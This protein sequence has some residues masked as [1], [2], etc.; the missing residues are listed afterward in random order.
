MLYSKYYLNIGRAT[1]LKNR[2]ERL[3][4]R[5]FEILP[6]F[7]IWTTLILMVFLSWRKPYWAAVFIII[8]CSYWILRTTHFTVHLVAAYRKMKQ[9][10]LINW[11]EKLDNL[12]K[13]S[14]GVKVKS[15]KEIYHLVILPMYKE[16]EEVIRGTMEALINSDYPKDKI[17]VV[18]AV[19]ERAG[20]SAKETANRME[21]EYGERFFRFLVT[22]HPANISGEIIGKGSNETWAG[23]EAKNKIIDVEKIPYENIVVSCLDIDTQV[24]P[25]YFSCLTYHYLTCEN[26]LR[27]SFQ[28]VPLY[29]NNFW[30]A[31]FFSR[32]VSALN[33]FWQMMQQQRPEKVITYSSHAMSFKALE[34]MDFWQTNVVSE[35]AGIFWKSFL[36][37]DG[38]YRVV[39]IHYLISMD[40]NVGPTLVQTVK[41][42]Y[43]QQRRWASGSEGIPYLL[44][45]LLKNRKIPFKKGFAYAF[46]I[47]EGFWAWATNAILILCLGWLPLAL[48]QDGFSKSMLAYNLPFITRNLMTIAMLGLLVCII[49]N[50]FL[51]PRP[52]NFN[53]LRKV[54]IIAQWLFFPFALIIF[55]SFPAIDAQ[56]RLMLG[57]YLGFWP[58]PK[59]RS[60]LAS[61]FKNN[62]I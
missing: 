36:F 3:I 33:V 42:V 40:A 58:T 59:F 16:G 20:E 8:F 55:G 37:Y 21:R 13:F 24:Y 32:L 39:P 60:K 48:S 49:I 11:I 61:K 14:Q 22:H 25:G 17:I 47:I 18:L 57:K 23:K 45:G 29:L 62:K 53:W 2:K 41:N 26:P 52:K 19:E 35:D 27:S 34:E 4:Y 50:T 5:I 7:F 28:P 54:S 6:G 30:D 10:L 12:K 44:F 38:D 56:T 15:W 9:N 46:L 31:P 43:L 51:V 1:D